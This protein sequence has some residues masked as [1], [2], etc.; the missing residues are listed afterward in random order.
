MVGGL[1]GIITVFIF[2]TI[3]FGNAQAGAN[4]LLLENGLYANDW[5]VFGAFICAPFGGLL[6]GFG[7]LAVR[8]AF[9]YLHAKI[10]GHKFDALDRPGYLDRPLSSGNEY[11]ASDEVH[12][13]V[14]AGTVVSD[15]KGKFF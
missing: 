14:Q 2:G 13:D 3:Y 1:G 15:H 6:W 9:Q 4:L 7:A 5:S 8:L 12:V 10:K 11:A